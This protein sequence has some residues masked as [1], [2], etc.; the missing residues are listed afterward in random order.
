MMK[1]SLISLAATLL[2]SA[3]PGLSHAEDAPAASPLTFNL[4]LTTKYKYR[5]Q[6]QSDTAKTFLP[7][8]LDYSAGG[9]Y[10]GNWN[11]SV[12][13]GG[14][15]EVDVYGGY[16]GEL[17]PGLGFDVGALQ[18]YYPG[19]GSSVFNTTEIYGALSYGI[20]SLK[21]SRTVSSK[22]FGVVDG[23][24]TGYFSPSW[25]LNA[26]IGATAFSS[27]GKDNG[28]VNYTDY[29]L[30]VTKDAG[31]GLSFS[32]AFVDANKDG[33]YGDINKGRFVLTLTKTM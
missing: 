17:S 19:T 15:T 21:Y 23:K 5:G 6:D 3:V 25:T 9:F 18:Y 32:G 26:H 12:G 16:K 10:V 14:G 1:K 30:G 29:K 2:V 11:S 27:G 20:A 8:G 22:Y 33:A 24:G 13:F 4:S 31:N 7:G 28:G